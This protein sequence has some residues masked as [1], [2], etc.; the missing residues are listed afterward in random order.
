MQKVKA[1]RIRK[2]KSRIKKIR[3]WKRNKK[4]LTYQWEPH[5]CQQHLVFD[6]LGE[7]CFQKHKKQHLKNIKNN[8]SVRKDSYYVSYL[9]ELSLMIREGYIHSKSNNNM[10]GLTI[11][12]LCQTNYFA[13][14]WQC[15]YLQEQILYGVLWHEF[16]PNLAKHLK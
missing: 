11:S 1:K 15:F 2:S 16:L 10:F 7:K 6:I 4:C 13:L 14:K 5:I 9:L 12:T 8:I 3:N